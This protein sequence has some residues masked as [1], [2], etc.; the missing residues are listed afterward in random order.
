MSAEE[1]EEEDYTL[2]CPLSYFKVTLVIRGKA[3]RIPA[4]HVRSFPVVITLSSLRLKAF[5]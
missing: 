1:E 4:D 2:Y 5:F 3:F